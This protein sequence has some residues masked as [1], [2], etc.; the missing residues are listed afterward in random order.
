M[1]ARDVFNNAFMLLEA[2]VT[3]S[4]I[5]VNVTNSSPAL[6]GLR[7]ETDSLSVSFLLNTV[8]VGRLG[9]HRVFTDYSEHYVNS[10]VINQ[11]I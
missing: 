3:L 1:K 2:H 6:P 5:T 9:Q 4:L 10:A 7:H 8:N 11:A